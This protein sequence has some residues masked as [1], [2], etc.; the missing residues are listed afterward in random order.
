MQPQ[1]SS[2]TPTVRG[3]LES[4][5]KFVESLPLATRVVLGLSVTL[6]FLSLLRIADI[7]S[8]HGGCSGASRVVEHYEI[9]RLLTA[10][11]LHVGLLH[12][13][14]NGSALVSLLPPVER[15]HGTAGGLMIV[16]LYALTAQ[17]LALVPAMLLY[18]Y[19][20]T[21]C[22]VGLSGMLFGLLTLSVSSDEAGLLPTRR[23]LFG[24]QIPAKSYPWVLALIIQLLAP[25]SSFSVHAGGIVAAYLLPPPSKL[26]SAITRLDSAFPAS[27]K[28]SQAYM[29]ANRAPLPHVADAIQ[30]GWAWASSPQQA[31]NR[32]PSQKAFPGTG[33]ALGTATA[34]AEPAEDTPAVAVPN[35][36]TSPAHRSSTPV[37]T[38]QT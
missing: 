24:Y 8:A 37:R 22:S 30:G 31:G 13:L 1:T 3:V 28:G 38:T 7:L 14:M 10:P 6:W 2:T 15:E 33:R 20:G 9:W 23:A 21:E 11:F 25:S 19:L 32:S 16:L 27:L 18:K 34:P 5:V 17:L 12:L 36:I 26:R 4:V 29:P 35:T